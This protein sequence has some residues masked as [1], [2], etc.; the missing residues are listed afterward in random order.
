[1]NS[2]IRK[3]LSSESHS[4]KFSKAVYSGITLFLAVT[5]FLSSCSGNGAE[6]ISSVSHTEEPVPVTQTLDPTPSPTAT[7]ERIAPATAAVNDPGRFLPEGEPT[8]TEVIVNTQVNEE[9][10]PRPTKTPR[11]TPTGFPVI[12]W[13]RDWVEEW[14]HY[15]YYIALAPFYSEEMS[16]YKH[17]LICGHDAWPFRYEG[18]VKEGKDLF[19]QGYVEIHARR[20]SY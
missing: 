9:R 1:M 8:A 12:P 15:G 5:I 6:S 7:Q 20:A 2:R 10:T 17:V 4:K 19:I 16:P 13:V 11:P 18:Y 3:I 14:S